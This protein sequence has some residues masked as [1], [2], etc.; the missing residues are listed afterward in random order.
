[1]V[2]FKRLIHVLADGKNDWFSEKWMDGFNENPNTGSSS[3][4]VTNFSTFPRVTG[5][6]R[7]PRKMN[8]T[9]IIR[10]KHDQIKRTRCIFFKRSPSSVIYSLSILICENCSPSESGFVLT[11]QRPMVRKITLIFIMRDCFT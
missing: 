9:L 2:K 11:Q 7:P 6:L 8:D 3:V 1:M 4:P 5:C 10:M